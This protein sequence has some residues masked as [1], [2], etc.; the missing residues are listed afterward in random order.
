MEDIKMEKTIEIDG[1]QVRFKAS[2]GTML[3]YKMQFGRE[4][5]ADMAD[6]DKLIGEDRTMDISGL[7]LTP[8]YRI[9]WVLAK[10]ADDS[11]PDMLTWYDSFDSFPLFEV[12][13][14][15]TEILQNN[16]KI[17]RKNS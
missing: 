6:I 3:R 10:T 12:V 8:F 1:R 4:Y 7:D 17:D 14:Q 9:V 11:I 13:E 16:I 15:L 2:G 5:L